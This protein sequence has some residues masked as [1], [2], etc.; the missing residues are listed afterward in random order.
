M[1]AFRRKRFDAVD[2]VLLKLP[3]KEQHHISRRLG[4]F[5]WAIPHAYKRH[6]MLRGIGDK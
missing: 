5:R 2:E 4:F 3:F 1:D 6:Q